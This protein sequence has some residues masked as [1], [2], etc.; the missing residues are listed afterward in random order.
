MKG[1]ILAGGTG[2]RLFPI[3]KAVVKQL[4]PV[5]DKPLIYYPLS[6]LMQAGIREILIITNPR[7]L[8][9]FQ[10]LFGDGSQ[11]GLSIQYITQAA[12]N[13]LAEAFIL[14]EDFIG[15]DDVCLVLGDNIFH[16]SGLTELLLETVEELDQ[17]GGGTIFG[18]YFPDPSAYGVVEFDAQGKVVS[19]EEKPTKPKS[20]FAIPGLYFYDHTVVDKAKT[21]KPSA[22]GELE[23]TDLHNLYLQAGNLRVKTLGRGYVWL[24]TGNAGHLHEAASFVETI[25]KRQGLYLAC[26]EEIAWRQGWIDSA[27][28]QKLAQTMSKTAYGQYL[29]N[30]EQYELSK[31]HF[32]GGVHSGA[33]DFQRQS[34]SLSGN[35]QDQSF[36][37]KSRT[38]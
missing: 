38:I 15:Q 21:I 2:S 13:G 34:R 1:I 37:R 3:T 18:Y 29:L 7:D 24:D 32:S 8:Q 16:G 9:S 23:I 30:L 33:K 6:V 4:L 19:I 25:Q 14:G 31:H 17:Q 11:L 36:S 35:L 12:P 20:N 22:R 27:Q 28:L 10:D 5:Y 26:L